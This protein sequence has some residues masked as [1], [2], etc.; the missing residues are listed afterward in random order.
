MIR[1]KIPLVAEA[2]RPLV[3]GR[4]SRMVQPLPSPSILDFPYPIDNR[5]KGNNQT[6][7]QGMHPC[8]RLDLQASNIAPDPT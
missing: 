8:E 7:E 4:M 2:C 3:S 1:T 6:Q 5:S